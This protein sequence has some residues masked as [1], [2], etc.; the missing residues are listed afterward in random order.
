MTQSVV[1]Q[2]RV[3][4]QAALAFVKMAAGPGYDAAAGRVLTRLGP[5]VYGDLANTRRRLQ[6]AS[7]ES[8][9]NDRFTADVEA[10]QWRVRLEDLLRNDPSLITPL[11]E[12]I[13]DASQS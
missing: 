10:S 1:H 3:A 13:E 4:F 2:P 11:A 5:Q 12:L 8:S 7:V 9:D 6:E